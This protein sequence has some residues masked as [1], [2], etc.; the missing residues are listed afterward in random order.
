MATHARTTQAPDPS[1]V[2]RWREQMD[3]EQRREFESIAGA[4]LAE[5]GYVTGDGP[6]TEP[7]DFSASG[8]AEAEGEAPAS[9]GAT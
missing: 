5:L 1:R 6:G 9:E 2:S 7:R 4:L 3:P 8:V